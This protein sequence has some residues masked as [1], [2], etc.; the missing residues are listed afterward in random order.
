MQSFDIISDGTVDIGF[1]HHVENPLINGIE[2]IDTGSQGG[3][4]G[5]FTAADSVQ[6][7]NFTG[8][9]AGPTSSMTPT[10]GWGPSRG[11]FMVD[12]TLYAVFADGTLTCCTFNG[13]TFGAVT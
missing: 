10:V 2:I 7:R 6:R 13:T 3:G 5:G 9:S 8:T 12:N 11:A 4:G 1:V